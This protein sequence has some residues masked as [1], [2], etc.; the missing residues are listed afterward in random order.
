MAANSVVLIGKVLGRLRK[1]V[2]DIALLYNTEDD[3]FMEMTVY[4]L[5]RYSV[6][7]SDLLSSIQNNTHSHP[8]VISE[9][10]DGSRGREGVIYMEDDVMEDS[11]LEET[12]EESEDESLDEEEYAADNAIRNNKAEKKGDLQPTDTEFHAWNCHIKKHG[13]WDYSVD[14][15]RDTPYN[16]QK[17]SLSMNNISV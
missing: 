10:S 17:R 3:H 4:K 11:E 1:G 5:W 7:K 8:D 16:K 2:Y 12:I 6:T 15:T 14:G 9:E 13:K